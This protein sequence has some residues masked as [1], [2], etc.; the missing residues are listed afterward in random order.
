MR[1]EKEKRT[2]RIK[3]MKERKHGVTKEECTKGKKGK[4][5]RKK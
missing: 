2:T 3:R 1:G 5:N 4:E